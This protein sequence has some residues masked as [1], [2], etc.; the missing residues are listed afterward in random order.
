M[1]VLLQ[2]LVAIVAA[3]SVWWLI[4]KM[5][6]PRAP[7]EPADDPLANVSAPLRR[8]PKGLAGAVAVEEPEPDDDDCHDA[9]PPR[10]L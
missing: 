10:S 7:A 4:R 6:R 9:Y 1:E 3:W 8:G 5:L 2:I